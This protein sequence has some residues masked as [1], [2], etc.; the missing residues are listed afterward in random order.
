MTRPLVSI[1]TPSYNQADFLEET[2][3]SILEQDYPH[4]EYVVVDDGS[5]DRSVDII[6]RYADRLHWWTQQENAGQVAAIN[7]GFEHTSGALMTYINSDDT[8]LPGAVSEMVAEFEADPALVMVYGDAV[9]TDASSR[10]TGPLASRDWDPPTMVRNCDNHVVQPS[11]MWTRA[12]WEQAGPFDERGYYFFDFELYLRFSVL[13]PVKHVPRVWST[14]REHDASKSAGD[15]LGKSRDYLRFADEF[16]TSDR[17]PAE[18]RPYAREGRARAR[19]A[20]ANN[21]YG[22]L[23]L[24]PARRWLWEALALHPQSA[25]RTSL[26]LAGKSLLPK[27]VVRRLRERRHAAHRG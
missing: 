13:G 1:V 10:Q 16:L 12:A 4:I 14:Y 18:L 25:T 27:P 15:Q 6:R 23:E 26:S 20:A 19:V 24:G 3:V 7:R 21:L 17:L 22:Q 2:L 9:Y 8:L 5:T 11:S